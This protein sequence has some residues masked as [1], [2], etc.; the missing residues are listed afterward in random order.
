MIESGLVSE[1]K[2]LLA[3][4]FTADLK[5]MQSLGYKQICAYLSGD[6]DL[7]TAI[8][9]IQKETRHFAK[10]QLTWWRR[11]QRVNWFDLSSVDDS[12]NI[13]PELIKIC[14]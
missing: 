7:H 12:S 6:Y 11:D 2:A 3:A 13:L 10:R 8:E 9:L 5:P 4:G 1:V 14:E